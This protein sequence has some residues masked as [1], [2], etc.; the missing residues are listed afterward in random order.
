MNDG[1]NS[2]VQN[3]NAPA[4]TPFYKKWWFIVIVVF[5]FYAIGSSALDDAKKNN[6]TTTNSTQEVKKDEA[7]K[8]AK[9]EVASHSVK[10]SQYGASSIVG[11]VINNGNAD[12][13]FVK[14]T[15]TYYNEQ[16]EVVDTGFTYAGDTADVALQPTK[17]APFELTRIENIKYANY[18]LDVSWND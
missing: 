2:Q 5:I 8:E 15:A 3:Q 11:E 1:N 6:S 4:A 14:V 12:V 13:T 18:K 17:K 7:K 10:K 9:V 16:G